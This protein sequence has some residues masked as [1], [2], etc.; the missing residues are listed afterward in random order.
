[1]VAKKRKY[2]WGFLSFEVIAYFIIMFTLFNVSGTT[3]V[4]FFLLNI[5]SI[6]LPGFVILSFCNI[7]LS[8]SGIFFTSYLF[9][10][11]FLVVEFFISEL[12]D[13]KL[14]FTNITIVVIFASV[15][16]IGK[17]INARKSLV[18]IKDTGNEKIEILF[19][20]FF[21][22]LN[23]FAYS[24]NFLGTD[25]AP[26]FEA[27]RDMQYWVNNTVALKLSWP[28]DNLFMAGNVLNY[29]Y[30]SNIPIAFL[31][32]VYQIDVFTMSFPLYGM[33]KA[34]VMVGV[35]QFLMD[36]LS[37]SKMINLLGYILL[38]FSTGAETITLVTFVNHNLLAPFGFDMGYAYGIFFV[39]FLV[40]Q[41]K[42]EGV[43]WRNI[44]GM[45]LAWVMCV[46]SKAP[47]ALV[48]II[49]A[50]FICLYWL[51]RKKWGLAFGYG[52]SILGS[53][54]LICKYCV[55]MFSVASGDSAWSLSLYGMDHFTYVLVAEPWDIIGRCMGMIG[56]KNPILG[57]LVKSICLNPAMAFGVIVIVIWIIYLIHE[58]KIEGKDIYFQVSLGV[59]ALWGICLWHLVNAGGF[60]EMYFAMAAL[61]PMAMMILNA[62]VLYCRLYG[63]KRHSDWELNEKLIFTVFLLFI[64]LGIFR[65]LWSGWNG[66]GA[67]TKV[68]D[69]LGNLYNAEHGYDDS[70]QITSGIRNTDV[71]ALSWIRDYADSDA[72]IMTDKA[73]MTDN[74]AYYMYGIFCERQQ[75]LEG[76]DMLGTQHQDINEEI[77]RRKE[78]ISG[79][80]N[81]LPGALLD[82]KEEGIDYIVQ[83]KDITPEFEYNPE[84]LE[85]VKSTNTMNIYRMK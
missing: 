7:K 60:S 76:I 18:E 17:R 14:S 74:T 40:R 16:I 24:A 84:Y 65:F 78:I 80:Y 37:D 68:C 59:T 23:I 27:R 12:V 31:C 70:E 39:A 35:V 15:L 42:T 4:K 36:A 73:I 53:F 10:Y 62:L 2:I 46:G 13:R 54:L 5:F 75:Y 72:L 66:I 77:T 47:V 41:W 57:L 22:F 71:E 64:Q 52:L 6:L 81:N 30:F 45:I 85:L 63:G 20:A 61:I 29:H 49:W 21:L 34:I 48:L 26:V 25:V 11:A 55:G 28:A 50:A 38:I 32:E 3:L 9:G 33:S 43:V 51:I 82:A 79:V 8:R 56:R 1:M 69:G 58:K 67:I 83:T 44:G 19:L